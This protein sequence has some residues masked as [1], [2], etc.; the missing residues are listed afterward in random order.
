MAHN[1]IHRCHQDSQDGE[2]CSNYIKVHIIIG[3]EKHSK[4]HGNLAYKMYIQNRDVN[5]YYQPPILLCLSHHFKSKQQKFI[6]LSSGCYIENLGSQ[7][8]RLIIGRNRI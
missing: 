7:A 8:M 5:N 4:N 6:A 3:V 1:L 2:H